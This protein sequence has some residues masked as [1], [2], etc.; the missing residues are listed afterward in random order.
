MPGGY[1]LNNEHCLNLNMSNY[2]VGSTHGM[3]P[4]GNRMFHLEEDRGVF[5]SEGQAAKN[6]GLLISRIFYVIVSGCGSL[7]G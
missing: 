7:W 4:V 1:D 5:Y 2:R 3:G 6:F